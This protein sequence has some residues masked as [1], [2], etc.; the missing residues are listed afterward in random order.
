MGVFKDEIAIWTNGNGITLNPGGSYTG[1]FDGGDGLA[2]F[3]ID[4]FAT[5]GIPADGKIY[6]D[7]ELYDNTDPNN[8]NW[9]SSGTLIAQYL[10]QD[11]IASVN[12]PVPSTF[13][14]FALG[15]LAMRFAA[16]RREGIKLKCRSL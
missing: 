14:L 8:P 3:A 5:W 16:R 9:I 1:I 6:M 15:A 13:S 7:Y 4:A 10:G 12:I 11:A 2:S